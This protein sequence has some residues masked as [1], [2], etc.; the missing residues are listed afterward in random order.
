AVYDEPVVSGSNPWN[1]DAAV[2]RGLHVAALHQ[3][4][5]TADT[6]GGLKRHTDSLQVVL[7][8]RLASLNPNVTFNG[9]AWADIERQVVDVR[10]ENVNRYSRGVHRVQDSKRVCCSRCCIRR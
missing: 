3:R 10:A 2:R 5:Q 4:E 1:R 8:Q 9:K 6:G 7:S